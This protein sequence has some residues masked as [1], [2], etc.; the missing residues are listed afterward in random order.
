MLFFF[1]RNTA[2]E[3]RISDW[4]SDLCSSDLYLQRN[5]VDLDREAGGARGGDPRQHARDLAVAGDV[6]EGL[7]VAAVEADVDPGPSR[8]DQPVGGRGGAGGGGRARASVRAP[9]GIAA[10][11]GS[12]SGRRL[13]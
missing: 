9:A 6:A 11:T 5:H 12:L 3:M 1:N 4:S 7:R 10:R 13:S 2:Y 8:G